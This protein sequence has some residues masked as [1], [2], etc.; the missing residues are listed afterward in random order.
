MTPHPSPSHGIPTEGRNPANYITRPPS[1]VH[2]AATG[3]NVTWLLI[4]GIALVVVGAL[5]M[6]WAERHAPAGR[7]RR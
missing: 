2:L 7:R 1:H 6:R 5:F 4:L 3:G